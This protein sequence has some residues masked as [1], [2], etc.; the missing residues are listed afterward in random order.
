M[1]TIRKGFRKNKKGKK[2]RFL[3]LDC[4]SKF[5]FNS[6]GQK[7]ELTRRHL[8]D[9]SSYRDIQRRNNCS[10]NTVMKYLHKMA[11]NAKN[12]F[13][14][15][16]NLKPKWSG[17]LCFDGTYIR[18]RNH[19]ANLARRKNWYEDE[20]FL[21]KMAAFLGT[22]YH[23]RDLPHY[24]IGDNENM[25]DLVM[26]FRQ[27]QANGYDLK[28]LVRDG[29]ERIT[30]AATKIYERPIVTQ[31]CHR[32]FLAK[33]DEKIT[34]KELKSQQECMIRLKDE[35]CCIIRVST[36]EEAISKMNRFMKKQ[37]QFR[38]SKNMNYLLDRFI[39]DFEELTMY[40][41]YPKGFVPT[42]V[43]VS[44]NMNKQLKDRLRTMCSL[45]SIRSAENYLKLWC[46]K[47]RFQR[48]TDCKK[49]HKHL[50]GKAPLEHAGCSISTLD[51]LN[52]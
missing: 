1:K 35:I 37:K 5:L 31:L 18:V 6:N 38:G 10:K 49:P 32:H 14:V 28:V 9:K 21:H 15:A 27:L 7:R 13:W 26:Y 42:T 44:E 12:S 36:I 48:F 34:C 3:C 50:N 11:G 24:S 51:Y 43:N 41:Q 45:Q 39:R 40:L 19:F 47:R 46:L 33:M 29:N 22:D 20:R 23:T 25:I 8:E 17:V 4:N 30:T 2:R 16:R 52:L